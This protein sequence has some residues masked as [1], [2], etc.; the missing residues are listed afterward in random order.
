M[1]VTITH[2]TDFKSPYAYL[3]KD[4]TY[5]LEDGHDVAIDWL[6]YTLDITDFLGSAAVD[7]QG[8]VVSER[9]TAHQ[10]RRVRYSYMDARRYANLRE[11]T[12]RGPR[13]IWDSSL[14]AIGLLWAKQAEPAPMRRYID[15]TFERF[16]RRDLDIEDVAVIED[17]LGD[18]GVSAAGFRSFV[19]EDGRARHDA[20]RAQAEAAG[21]FGVPSYVL[22]GELFW[23]REHLDLIGLRLEDLGVGTGK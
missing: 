14:A 9:R 21:V 18:A 16:W 23:G 15:A 20:I 11:L 6:P 13:K 1:T 5:R 19:D 12:I 8:H 3:A 17:M 10:W 7:E 22:D 4:P 2:Y